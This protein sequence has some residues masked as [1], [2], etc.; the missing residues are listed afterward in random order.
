MAQVTPKWEISTTINRGFQAI[1]ILEKYSNDLTKRLKSED[2]ELLRT[3]VPE[4]ELRRSGQPETLNIQKTTTQG[5]KNVLDSIHTC[6]VDIRGMVKASTTNPE[7]VQAFGVGEPL[8][9]KTPRDHRA[10]ANMI[11]TGYN[12]NSEWAKNEAGILEEDIQEIEALNS[13]LTDVD[14]NQDQ[15]KLNR[16]VKTIDK[17]LLQRQVETVIT[18]I[19]AV[20]IKEFRTKNPSIIPLFEALVSSTGEGGSGES[21]V[22]KPAEKEMTNA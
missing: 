7:I 14:S 9:S 8:N 1:G 10:A 2:V 17:D 19:S 20:G 21:D 4:L 11:I 12:T 6:I 3:G 5:K 16:K 18:K 15:A 22:E 13:R